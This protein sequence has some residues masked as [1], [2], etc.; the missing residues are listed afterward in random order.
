M[1]PVYPTLKIKNDADED[2]ADNAA[3]FEGITNEDIDVGD[4]VI[5]KIPVDKT[6]KPMNSHPEMTPYRV[7]EA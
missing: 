3:A 6:P 2:H 4:Y 5:G 1:S 7:G